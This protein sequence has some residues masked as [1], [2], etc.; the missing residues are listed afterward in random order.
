MAPGHLF[1]PELGSLQSVQSLSA[2]LLHVL[3]PPGSGS[4]TG[5]KTRL[6]LFSN[7]TKDAKL[8]L[9]SDGL[10][11][12]C[13]WLFF[14]IWSWPPLVKLLNMDIV[15]WYCAWGYCVFIDIKQCFL[16][17]VLYFLILYPV[18]I[19]YVQV[20]NTFS[21]TSALLPISPQLEFPATILPGQFSV[22]KILHRNVCLYVQ[23]ELSLI[24]CLMNGKT[25]PKIHPNPLTAITANVAILKSMHF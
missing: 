17:W 24:L 1:Q 22:R 16:L 4:S 5:T 19:I 20:Q 2:L 23:E 13:H 18:L 14:I 3:P 6:S 9:Y 8:L 10:F 25:H 7:D 12:S 21:T 15:L 11:A